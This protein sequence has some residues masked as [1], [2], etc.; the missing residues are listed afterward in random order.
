M[1]A[2]EEE[3]TQQVSLLVDLPRCVVVPGNGDAIYSP[4]QTPF[5]S[6]QPVPMKTMSL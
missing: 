5:L 2:S 6:P 1:K 4:R 3:K